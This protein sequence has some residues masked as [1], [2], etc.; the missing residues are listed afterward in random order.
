M[1]PEVLSEHV[2]PRVQESTLKGTR[3]IEGDGEDGGAGENTNVGGQGSW[4]QVS[5]GQ[6]NQ[7]RGSWEGKRAFLDAAPSQAAFT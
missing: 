1:L 6:W 4:K 3:G 7:S 2:C 5:L